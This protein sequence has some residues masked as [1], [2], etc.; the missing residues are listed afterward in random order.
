MVALILSGPDKHETESTV[1]P[2]LHLVAYTVGHAA[3]GIGGAGTR[4]ETKADVSA[5]LRR[6]WYRDA[7]VQ[8]ADGSDFGPAVILRVDRPY[9]Q[10]N[11]LRVVGHRK[12]EVLDSEG[13][14]AR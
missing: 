11:P 4:S 8:K 6:R 9:I 14:L 1:A 3:Y 10:G 7:L 2:C 12:D 5:L 13:R